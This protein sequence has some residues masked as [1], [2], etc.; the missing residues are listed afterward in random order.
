MLN[1]ASQGTIKRSY[2]C[3]F[4]K[5]VFCS[6]SLLFINL[7]A[8][9]PNLTPQ[10]YYLC[11]MS[12]ESIISNW[13]K[14]NFK[15]VY[16]LEGEESFFIDKVIH[17]AEHN[18]L[19]ENE[20]G[21]NLSVFYGKDADWTAVVNACRRYPMFAER[22]VVLLKEAQHMRDIEKLENYIEKPLSS[23][24]FVIGFKDKKIDART[25][26]AKT[27]KKYGE[28]L[29]SAKLKDYE[30]PAWTNEYIQQ[31]GLT[32]THKGLQMLVDN[33]GSDLSR[34][35]NE[36]DKLVIN[37]KGRKSITEED[38]E[39][40]IGISKEFNPFELQDA[41]AKKDMA[42]TIRIIQYF[43]HNPKAGPIQLVLPTLYNYFSKV[44]AIYGLDDKSERKVASLFYNNS[45][46]AKQALQTSALYGYQ[47][48]EKV[49][50]LLHQYNL[51]SIGIDDTGT[52]DADLMKELAVK[53]MS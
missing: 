50:L 44:Y 33:I 1:G 5:P 20:A 25:K 43:E 17:Y 14:N 34:I 32:V 22:Q 16:W 39:Q 37:L 23:T 47:G 12:A 30:L 28:V 18:I 40:Y 9:S 27:I 7:K 41:L 11:F 24:I 29:S 51:R 21:F 13:K 45:Y 48:I 42:K 15:P 26:F 46:A 38:I 49:L 4:H 35:A 2:N 31:Q 10:T 3:S 53:M 36:I 19:T 52:E 6:S 8:D